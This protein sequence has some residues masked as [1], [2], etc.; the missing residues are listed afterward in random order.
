MD[1]FLFFFKFV[2]IFFGFTEELVKSCTIFLSS[3]INLPA[4]RCPTTYGT[5]SWLWTPLR[6][7]YFQALSSLTT[8]PRTLNKY[9]HFL[10]LVASCFTFLFS[11]LCSP[12]HSKT[13]SNI[14]F[15]PSQD[16]L[17]ITVNREDVNVSVYISISSSRSTVLQHFKWMEC[18][19]IL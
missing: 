1:S 13:N 11:T 9:S 18:L 17:I 12:L 16:L 4:R 8:Y 15:L 2:K 10:D 6:I 14:A 7:A 3:S 5:I 19:I